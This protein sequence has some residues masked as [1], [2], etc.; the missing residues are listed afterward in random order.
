MEK[1]GRWA[2]AMKYLEDILDIDDHNLT[3][4][5]KKRGILEKQGRWDD[6]VY[7]QKAI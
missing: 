5:Y 1:T 7:L 3:A 4:M 6:L 2:E